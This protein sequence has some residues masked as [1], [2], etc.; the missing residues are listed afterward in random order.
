MSKKSESIRAAALLIELKG[1]TQ[2]CY[3]RNKKG[4]A[5]V[6]Q[7]DEAICYCASGAMLA[8]GCDE[9]AFLA[10]QNKLGLPIPK[11]NDYRSQTKEEVI[12]TLREIA[13]QLEE[14]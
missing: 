11:W 1:W 12:G 14:D 9:N 5:V 2:D 3:A 4:H 13:L 7:T 8:A 10:V 6:V